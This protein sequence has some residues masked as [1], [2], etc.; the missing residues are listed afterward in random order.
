MLLKEKRKV[1]CRIVS[2]PSLGVFDLQPEQYK[3]RIFTEGVPVFALT[4]GLPSLFE[5]YAGAKGKVF[6]LTHFGYSA[7]A[8]VLDEKF[9]FTTQN[10]CGKIEEMFII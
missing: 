4:A 8:E 6:G 10:I 5:K 1:N 7:P 3:K 2:M 9:G